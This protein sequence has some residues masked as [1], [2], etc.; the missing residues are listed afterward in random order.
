MQFEKLRLVLSACLLIL[1]LGTL[2]RAETLD[3]RAGF[4]YLVRDQSAVDGFQ[5]STVAF[6]LLPDFYLG[7]TVYSAYAGDAGGLY[8]GGFEAYRRF[9]FNETTSVDVGAFIGGGGGAI[10]VLGDG[11]MTKA[12]VTL[13][14]QFASGFMAHVGG[15]WTRITGSSINT[16]HLT[17]AV[18]RP[19]ELSVDKGHQRPRAVGS[20]LIV[21][22]VKGMARVYF[23][24]DSARRDNPG[25]MEMMGLAG[26]EI[27]VRDLA[28]EN[29]EFFFAAMG[30]AYNDGAGYAEWLAGPRY[31]TR[32][33]AGGRLRA[34]AD[35][36][37]GTSGG[38]DVDT[39]GGLV[40]AASA[41]VDLKV[42]GGF[43]VE[44]G[45]MGIAA[46][47]GDFRAAA[48]FLRGALRFDD[49]QSASH[50]VDGTTTRHWRFSTGLSYQAAHDGFRPPGHQFTGGDP[51]LI[52]SGIDLFFGEHFYFN[53][54]GY[55]VMYGDAGGF[56]MGTVGVG[57]ELPLGDDWAL[58]AEGFVGA[59]A[60]GGIATGGGLIGG[61]KLELDYRLND[62]LTLSVGAGKWYS[63]GSASPWTLHGGVKIP[64]TSY[65]R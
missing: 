8:L 42:G 46:M 55:T 48:A 13:N 18:S 28:N 47:D 30:A 32:P 26:G 9:H 20:G 41:G 14:H 1:G 49:P 3:V 63:L 57:Y 65:H 11:L 6:E 15:G 64:L 19:L 25:E 43:H 35:V 34:F 54:S 22:S 33:L 27:T 50:G 24:L 60:G 10:V 58:A 31:Y 23:P 56:A 62:G 5:Y 61:G 16:P 45:I 21:S 39:G 38:G 2:A 7:E 52:E 4:D 44:T 51:V 36:G 59:A 17:F 53:G 40:A 29:L 12:Q 37:I